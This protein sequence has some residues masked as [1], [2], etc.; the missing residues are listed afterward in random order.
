MI[1]SKDCEIE[2]LNGELAK[3]KKYKDSEIEEIARLFVQSQDQ[4]EAIRQSVLVCACMY[5]NPIFLYCQ[6]IGT[7]SIFAD[8]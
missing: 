4:S 6:Y 8:A 5:T 1:D 2:E 3:L 7:N